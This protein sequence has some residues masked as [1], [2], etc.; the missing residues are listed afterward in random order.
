MA[1]QVSG[2]NVITNARALNNITSVDST[3]ATAIGNAGVGGG[4]VYEYD[5]VFGNT[6]SAYTKPADG[7]VLNQGSN[8]FVNLA[9]YNGTTSFGEKSGR[10]PSTY[11]AFSTSALTSSQIVNKYG[12]IVMKLPSASISLRSGGYYGSLLF[13]TAYNSST[14]K[15]RILAQYGG[16]PSQTILP[17]ELIVDHFVVTTGWAL[18]LYVS[19]AYDQAIYNENLTFSANTI[20]CV[21]RFLQV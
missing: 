15:T 11:R 1:I 19:D 8:F 17:K 9:L 18:E 16:W 12:K 21:G 7:V 2:T 13:F 5:N 6:H 3:T 20:S 14:N 4:S 10:G